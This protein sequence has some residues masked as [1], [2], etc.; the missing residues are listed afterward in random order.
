MNNDTDWPVCMWLSGTIWWHDVWGIY[1][2][3]SSLARWTC[4]LTAHSTTESLA[5]GSW[6]CRVGTGCWERAVASVGLTLVILW[7]GVLCV[8]MADMT[9]VLVKGNDH[10]WHSVC[11]LVVAVEN[12]PP[13]LALFK[14]RGWM[15]DLQWHLVKQAQR[16]YLFSV[17][18]L[19]TCTG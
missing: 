14:M 19:T 17:Q 4:Y 3:S 8:D 5:P 7:L 12:P 18:I 9:V 10:L 15:S 11:S 13:F 2:S 1:N 6:S 16:F